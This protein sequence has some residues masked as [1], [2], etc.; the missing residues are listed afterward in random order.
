MS[1]TVTDETKI[2]GATLILAAARAQRKVQLAEKRLST[3][4]AEEHVALTQLHKF[5]AKQADRRL[6]EMDITIGTVWSSMRENN[7]PFPLSGTIICR[8]RTVGRTC[9][10]LNDQSKIFLIFL[11]S[12]IGNSIISRINHS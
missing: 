3:C 6:D 8:C 1:S 7:I 11:D 9:E 4:L 10:C 2:V 12:G 5:Q